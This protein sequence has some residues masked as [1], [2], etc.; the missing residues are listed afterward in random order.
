MKNHVKAVY[1]LTVRYA[2]CFRKFASSVN[3]KYIRESG[4]THI[5][6]IGAKINVVNTF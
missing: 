4:V 2:E 1:L 3:V 5:Y 6:I